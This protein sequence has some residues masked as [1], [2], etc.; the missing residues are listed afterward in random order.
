MGHNLEILWQDLRFA[1]RM[2]RKNFGLTILIVIILSLG[3]GANTAIFTL[4]NAVIIKPLPVKSPEQLVLFSDSA[5]EGTSVGDPPA[6]QWRLF[7]YPS[8]EYF[9]NNNDLFQELCAFRSGEAR[10]NVRL[11]GVESGEA[12]QRAQGHLVSGNFFATLG[13]NAMLGRALTPED[14]RPSA[15][16]AAVISYGYWKATCGGDAS[17]VNKSV[18]LNGTPFTIVGVMPQEFFGV[19]VRRS[20]DFWL[21][22]NFQPQIELQESYLAGSDYYWLNIMGRLKPGIDIQQAR[23]GV[24]L[25]LRQFLIEQAGSQI[26]EDRQRTS[27]SAYVDLAYGGRG[28]SGLRSRFSEPLQMLMAVVAL[29]QIGR[30][31]CRERV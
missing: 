23:S 17:V 19:R 21:P 26:T 29:I 5:S 28:I 14:D 16:P 13:V 24:N 27:Q 20:P 11:E 25:A 18:M 3:I 15:S 6:E 22:L 7:S 30:A 4:L 8:Y 2:L 1:M 10:L 9:R 31:S 12:A